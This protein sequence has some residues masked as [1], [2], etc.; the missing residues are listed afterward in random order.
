MLRRGVC[1]IARDR[2]DGGAWLDETTEAIE[3]EAG[4]EVA[5][6]GGGLVG[7]AANASAQAEQ[8]FEHIDEEAG[9]RQVRP[10][11]VRGDVEQD[12]PALALLDAG[13][14]RRAVGERGPGAA[15]ELERGL[16]Q[17]LALHFDVGGRLEAGE[18]AG[19]GEGRERLRL[20]PGECAAQSA[21]ARLAQPHRQQI[22]A[23]RCE[24]RPRKTHQHAALLDPFRQLRTLFAGHLSDIGE[25]EHGDAMIK[26]L[27]DRGGARFGRIFEGPFQI[28]GRR[29]QRLAALIAGDNADRATARAFI[30]ERDGAG[31]GAA[32]DRQPLDIVAQAAGRFDAGFGFGVAGGEGKGRCGDETP[33]FA[34]RLDVAAEGEARGG[35][36]QAR[37]EA[38]CVEFRREQ[39][40]SR[41]GAIVEKNLRLA[42]AD[43]RGDDIGGA[44][45]ADSVG[46]PDDAALPAAHHRRQARQH[47]V[48][49]AVEGLGFERHRAG[50]GVGGI[51]L[52]DVEV[53]GGGGRENHG[54]IG[55]AGVLDE[56]AHFLAPFV[57]AMGGR[58]AIVDDQNERAV[59]AAERLRRIHQRLG[60]RENDQ[61]RSD[62]AQDQQPERRLVRR[63]FLGLEAGKE[64]Q[65]EK[66]QPPRGRRRHPQQPPDD[67]QRRQRDQRERRAE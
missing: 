33:A 4:V 36:D 41:R 30:E 23:A 25:D 15:L 21:R 38:V 16:S 14:E 56:A 47:G 2:R 42:E 44:G 59:A 5:L 34:E 31:A 17:D 45:V 63:L 53:G 62:D 51:F 10:F 39:R 20:F 11:R 64:A 19:P 9:Q 3:H 6:G 43:K 50:E 65:A 66:P 27:A 22:V 61:R 52:T 37:R 40:E 58:P 7:G 48:A 46:K 49:I 67:R 54:Q 13:D 24:A 32:V 57:P 28:V 35:A 18:G 26:V 12:D 1:P 60:Q 29:E 8:T 55:A